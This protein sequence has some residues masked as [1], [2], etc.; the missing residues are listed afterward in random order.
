[1]IL[2]AAVAAGRESGGSWD[3]AG[4]QELAEGAGP[5]AKQTLGVMDS[6]LFSQRHIP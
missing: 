4:A 3:W 5:A 6:T 2:V 1:M